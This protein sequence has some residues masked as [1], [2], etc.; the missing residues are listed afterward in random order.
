MR[1]LSMV[2]PIFFLFCL[3]SHISS[4]SSSTPRYTA[5]DNIAINC[6]TRGNS[7]AMDNRQ[8]IGDIHSNFTPI[9][10]A[11]LKSV[12]STALRIGHSIDTVPYLTARLSY[13]QFMYQFLVTPGPKFVRLYFNPV[14]YLGFIGSQ[15]FFTVK[16]GSFT[17]LRNFSASIHANSLTEDKTLYKEFCI[18]VEKDQKLNLTFIPISPRSSSSKLYAFI[19]GI[20]IV[21]MPTNL[22]YRPHGPGVPHVGQNSLFS[23]NYE[24]ALEMVFRFNVGGSVIS[25][26]EDTGMFRAWSQLPDEYYVM[27][28]IST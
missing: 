14:P 27:G 2:N 23:I 22:Y 4:V 12:A 10:E 7:T 21:S 9:E 25:P 5:A 17:L 3:V 1:N 28:V 6:G 26:V 24:M 8:W 20:E 13:S 19:N 18:N 11:D 15:D 16:A